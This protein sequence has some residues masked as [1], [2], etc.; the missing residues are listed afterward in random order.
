LVRGVA[1]TDESVWNKFLEGTAPLA[2]IAMKACYR[3][4]F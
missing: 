1:T 4:V 2:A 3:Q